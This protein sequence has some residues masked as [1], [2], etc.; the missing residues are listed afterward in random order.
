MA[1]ATQ[2]NLYLSP[3]QQ[4]LLLAALTSNSSS[5]PMFTTPSLSHHLSQSVSTKPSRGGSYDQEETSPA[6]AN[7]VNGTPLLDSG[8]ELA[9]WEPEFDVDGQWDYDFGIGEINETA[10]SSTD[11]IEGSENKTSG[12]SPTDLGKS[13][14]KETEKRK[15][16]PPPGESGSVDPHDAE[17][18][19]RGGLFPSALLHT[20]PSIFIIISMII[21]YAAITIPFVHPRTP[22]A[23]FPLPSFRL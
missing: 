8:L 4:D 5:S 3:D 2:D 9:D 13:N 6:S 7:F 23:D 17:P 1:T 14:K 16:P 11:S 20:L 12:A 15:D 19:R 18:K 21:K 10:Q 22:R